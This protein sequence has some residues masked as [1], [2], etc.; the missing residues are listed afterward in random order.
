MNVNS[1]NTCMVC[2]GKESEITLGEYMSKCI[3]SPEISENIRQPYCSVCKEI[4]DIIEVIQKQPIDMGNGIMSHE[5]YIGK[6]LVT[7]P[8]EIQQAD[9]INMLRTGGTHVLV[10]FTMHESV[11]IPVAEFGKLT[12]TDNHMSYEQ[13]CMINEE[14]TIQRIHHDKGTQD[15]CWV[16]KSDLDQTQGIF[17]NQ[18]ICCRA[19]F[20]GINTVSLL[21]PAPVPVYDDNIEWME[22]DDEG[23][24]S[25]NQSVD[26]SEDEELLHNEWND[27]VTNS[28]AYQHEDGA[29]RHLTIFQ[30][31]ESM[32]HRLPDEFLSFMTLAII[33]NCMRVFDCVVTK[34]LH[35]TQHSLAH[36]QRCM[37]KCLVHAVETF[38]YE[39]VLASTLQHVIH[40][41]LFCE[42]PELWQSVFTILFKLLDGDALPDNV[43]LVLSKF[44]ILLCH[45][46]TPL[47]TNSS[48][49]YYA[50]FDG[51]IEWCVCTSA[52][53]FTFA[54]GFESIVAA[55]R[56]FHGVGFNMNM[57]CTLEKLL[58][59]CRNK[60]R[61]SGPR[62][63]LDF[64][65]AEK[66]ATI[67]RMLQYYQEQMGHLTFPMNVCNQQNRNALFYVTNPEIMKFLL[68]KGVNPAN[69]DENGE[70]AVFFILNRVCQDCVLFEHTQAQGDELCSC[71][72]QL[73]S[74][75]VDLDDKSLA[76]I[77]SLVK[78][79]VFH[80]PVFEKLGNLF[81][82]FQLRRA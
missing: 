31:H 38:Q 67:L 41:E 77:S 29:I 58:L 49:Q 9:W 81:E 2:F 33:E 18:C 76:A 6:N 54:T 44:E 1:S 64:F 13:A 60:E 35:Q 72:S 12:V 8:G 55:T 63:R 30:N 57:L 36:R 34:Y 52:T 78:I 32:S 4:P 66:I 75:R 23:S 27:R 69:K 48:R 47:S 28:I 82:E 37:R 10:S 71:I 68:N 17:Y 61:L 20:D 39:T 42:D 70:T 56:R 22:T 53:T 26:E 14:G 40:S 5:R 7:V 65:S 46:I 25:A 73:L 21:P 51:F 3:A 43:E 24:D 79:L 74:Y 11:N 15:S 19:V 59:I 62:V 50:A 16:H 80:R 45:E